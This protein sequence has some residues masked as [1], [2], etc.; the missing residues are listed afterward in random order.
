MLAIWVA[1][2][3]I[4]FDK[5]QELDWF[6]SHFINWLLVIS[7]VFM[8]AFLVRELRAEHPVVTLRVFKIRSFSTG[9]FLMSVLGFVL[10]G[11]I[12]IIPIWLQT[13]LGYSAVSAGFTMLRE[14]WGP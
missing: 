8:I 5:G 4:A 9:V 1:A 11:S 7:G 10:Y 2:L 6:S 3:Q 12:V 14:A 13:L